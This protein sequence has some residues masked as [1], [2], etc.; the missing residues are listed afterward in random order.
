[1]KP[2]TSDAAAHGDAPI[3][4]P[5]SATAI[6]GEPDEF[7]IRRRASLERFI[8]RVAQHPVLR[9]DPDFREFVEADGQLPKASNTSAFSVAAGIRFISR[10]GEQMTK[11]T[12]KMEEKDPVSMAEQRAFLQK[13]HAHTSLMGN[14]TAIHSGSRRNNSILTPW[15]SL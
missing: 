1:M 14:P 8:N 11:M 13:S 9:L 10:F 3:A 4:S 12:Y 15:S 5:S 6:G 7:I 2:K